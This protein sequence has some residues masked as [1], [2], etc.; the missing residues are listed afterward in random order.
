MVLTAFADFSDDVGGEDPRWEMKDDL[1]KGNGSGRAV[2]RVWRRGE[3]RHPEPEVAK[4]EGTSK[5][6]IQVHDAA[7]LPPHTMSLQFR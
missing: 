6:A 5:P 1:V 7:Y 3:G 4:R 2:W